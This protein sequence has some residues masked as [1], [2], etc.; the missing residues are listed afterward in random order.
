[1]KKSKYIFIILAIVYAVMAFLY[2]FA[3]LSIGDNLLFALSAS[4]L[5]ISTSDV[6]SKIVSYLCIKNTYYANLKITIGF[7]ESM[8]QGGF[9]N[10]RI[11][12]VRNVMENYNVLLKNNYKFCH[13]NDYAKKSSLKI[14]NCISLLLFIFGIT[15]FI[16]IP[17]FG[18]NMSDTKSTSIITILAFATMAL[19]LFFDE[20][21]DEKQADIKILIN[22]KHLLIQAEYPTFKSYFD[23]HMYYQ[24]DLI[25]NQEATTVNSS[26]K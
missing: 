3:I 26:D 10:T 2:P 20:L 1:M 4:A 25:A 24:N 6:V 7:L 21:I 9:T 17:F 22:E 18:F 16:I 23:S 5:L 12:N 8:I 13:P 11:I 15:A 19:S 14:L